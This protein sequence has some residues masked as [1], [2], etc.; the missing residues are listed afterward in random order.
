M[1]RDRILLTGTLAAVV[2]ATLFGMLGP[3]A[4]FGAEAGVDGVAFTAWRALLGVLFLGAL[5]VVRGGLR[6]TA[7]ALRG[8]SRSGRLT[9]AVA[10][11]MALLLN[12]AMF[13]AFGLIPIAL[14][15][16]LFYTYP[17]GVVVVEVVVG[18]ERITTSRLA[19]LGLSSLGV[20]LVLVGGLDPGTGAPLHPLG[21][22]LGLVAA[23]SQVVFVT[24]SRSGYRSVPADGATLVILSTSLVGAALIALLA[25][26]ADDLIAPFRSLDPVP[27]IVVA[28]VVSAG[29][30]SLLFLTAIR[31]IGG[32]RTGILMLLEP[33]VGTILAGLWLGEAL[34]PVQLAGAALV[35]LGALV[36]QV[37][38]AP[39]HEPVPG[40]AAGPVA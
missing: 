10:A 4:R 21:I 11:L 29:L 34:S 31:A 38:G 26:Q 16:M 24:V 33:V 40:S 36:L 12:V 35:L 17:A 20:V 18:R 13:T 37:R 19:A 32:T 1:P 3:L 30:A 39:A 7:A 27:F 8:L 5:L 25:G 23:A 6:E 9:L 22:V 15:L 2:A 28:G 14:T